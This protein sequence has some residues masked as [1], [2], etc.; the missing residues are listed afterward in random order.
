MSSP[1]PTPDDHRSAFSRRSVLA[2]GL[3]GAIGAATAS[4]AA[5]GPGVGPRKPGEDRKSVV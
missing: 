2:A 3:A 5:G 1:R 4:Q